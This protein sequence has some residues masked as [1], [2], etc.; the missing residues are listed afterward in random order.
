MLPIPQLDAYSD[1]RASRPL[2]GIELER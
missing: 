1:L 2:A